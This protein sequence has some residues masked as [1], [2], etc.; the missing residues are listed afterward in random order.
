MMRNTWRLTSLVALLIACCCGSIRAAPITNPGD[1]LYASIFAGTVT[2]T[3]GGNPTA[4]GQGW[5]R[6]NLTTNLLYYTSPIPKWA[7]AA[8]DPGV[9]GTYSEVTNVAPNKLRIYD[10]Y[11]GQSGVGWVYTN[12]VVGLYVIS[13]TNYAIGWQL[14][15]EFLVKTN[16]NMPLTSLSGTITQ[17]LVKG[18]AYTNWLGRGGQLAFRGWDNNGTAAAANGTISDLKVTLLALATNTPAVSLSSSSTSIPETP[19][20]GTDIVTV[21]LSQVTTSDVTVYLSFGGSAVLGMDYSASATQIVISAGEQSGII[22]LTGIDN[23]VINGSRTAIVG[24]GSL[25]NASNGTP[26][27]VSVA[28]IDDETPITSLG[29][30]VKASMFFGTATNTS[31][32]NPNLS[33]QGWYQKDLT[34]RLNYYTN[35]AIKWA[36]ST[37]AAASLYSEVILVSTNQVRITD[38]YYGGLGVG[39]VYS[40][41]VVGR[42]VIS[43]AN[44]TNGSYFFS[45]FLV[46]SNASAPWVALSTNMA[47]IIA[48]GVAYTNWLSRG[49]KVAYRGW[50][51]CSHVSNASGSL[52]DMKVTLIETLPSG[53]SVFFR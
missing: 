45:Q 35:P 42:Y 9:N 25:V 46:K 52:T 36:T 6:K 13:C 41:Q 19:L 2:N 31:A 34:N 33:G 24:I 21:A 18:V 22:T 29:N 39:W 44:I 43:C 23:A 28:I 47:G 17:S 5:Y 7:T 38:N 53:T 4:D 32:G 14:W 49:G 1:V 10:I 26:S 15:S 37:N 20:Y 51:D 27:S 40:N 16:D 48:N 30:V 11:Y 3:S 50:N 12:Q 8:M